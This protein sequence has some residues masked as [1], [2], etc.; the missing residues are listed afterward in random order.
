MADRRSVYNDPRVVTIAESFVCAADEVW[1]LQRGSEADCVFFQKAVNGG[2]RIEDRGSRQGTW[3]FTP[4]GTLLARLNGRHNVVEFA[5]QL[6]K[7]LQTWD[8][9]EPEEKLSPERQSLLPA[10]HWEQN[11]PRQGLALERI[12]RD[13]P[14]EGWHTME[15][16]RWNID[17]AWFTKKEIAALVS[18][19]TEP[20]EA[21]NQSWNLDFVA[22]RLARFHLVDNVRGQSLPYA[23]G[24]VLQASLQAKVIS[25]KQGK[26]FLELQGYTEADAKGPWLLGPSLWQPKKEYPRGIQCHLLGK[27]ILDVGTMQFE[28]FELVALGR[29]WGRTQ[30]NG[31][32]ADRTPGLIAFHLQNT[33]R[34]TVAPTFIAVY[35]GDWVE[36]P[37]IPTWL[38][39]PEEC[40]TF[41]Q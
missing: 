3:I 20:A 31:R 23:D 21:G 12:A 13:V 29:R 36:K 5:A 26:Y 41:E 35:D 25:K 1:R 17:Y 18:N 32:R 4:K 9:L 2:K 27:A 28:E 16:T 37:V 6:E 7:Q 24:E 10:H 34:K 33:S 8:H 19:L 30:H 22:R 39:S 15:S 38:H 14:A 11:Y 40:Q